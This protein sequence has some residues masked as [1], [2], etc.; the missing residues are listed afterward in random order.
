[1]PGDKTGGAGI[2]CVF[3]GK[4][5]VQSDHRSLEWLHRLKENKRLTD[6]VESI[7]TAV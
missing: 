4:A 6:A 3:A 2:P 7:I 1:M 5:V